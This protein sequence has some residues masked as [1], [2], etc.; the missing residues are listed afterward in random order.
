MFCLHSCGFY[1]AL[2]AAEFSSNCKTRR[3]RCHKYLVCTSQQVADSIQ[4]QN[5][6]DASCCHISVARHE[7]W[8]H[9]VEAG[10]HT[11]D[12]RFVFTFRQ[13]LATH[14]Y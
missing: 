13:H 7:L 10:T 6:P 3:R 1:N 5:A 2:N 11:S 9:A 8:R 4:I 12:C 14:T